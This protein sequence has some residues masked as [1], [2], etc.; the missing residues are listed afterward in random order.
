MW[1][2]QLQASCLGGSWTEKSS[3]DRKLSG[4]GRVGSATAAPV[5][6]LPVALLFPPAPAAVVA[7][8]GPSAM[9]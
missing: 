4:A 5:P 2:G 6:Q 9:V 7:I 8:T 1:S 3:G